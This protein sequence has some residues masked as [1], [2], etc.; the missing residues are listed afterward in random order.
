M[1]RWRYRLFATAGKLITRARPRPLIPGKAPETG[2]ITTLLAAIAELKN[3]LR[4]QAPPAR[5]KTTNQPGRE[6]NR[7]PAANP[8]IMKSGLTVSGPA[9][10][11]WT[12]IGEPAVE[13]EMPP[14]TRKLWLHRIRC[15]PAPDPLSQE[16]RT[17]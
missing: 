1:K 11:R 16:H 14:A 8:T 17:R 10:G 13:Y 6:S 7:D 2:T 5:P 3:N 9:V 15:P 12:G 4:Q